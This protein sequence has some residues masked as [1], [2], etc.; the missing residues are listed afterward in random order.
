MTLTLIET[1]RLLWHYI[2]CKKDMDPATK[3]EQQKAGGR[4]LNRQE[5]ER[6]DTELKT[7]I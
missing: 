6:K 3:R 4:R 7:I 5:I 2:V 1:R